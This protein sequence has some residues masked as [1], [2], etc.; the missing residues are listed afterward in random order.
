MSDANAIWAAA[1]GGAARHA[2][3]TGADACLRTTLL[4]ALAAGCTGR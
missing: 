1:G 4:V 2:G 3:T